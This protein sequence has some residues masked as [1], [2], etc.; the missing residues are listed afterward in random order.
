MI[1]ALRAPRTP[2]LAAVSRVVHLL[3]E[4]PL[5]KIQL[6]Q[7]SMPVQISLILL[8]R[9]REVPKMI[10]GRMR[11]EHQIEGGSSRIGK[12]LRCSQ[13]ETDRLKPF[14]FPSS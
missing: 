7:Q 10:R 14:P 9:I 13:L 8:G 1:C 4:K 6:A 3:L 11:H 2:Y 12:E 5:S